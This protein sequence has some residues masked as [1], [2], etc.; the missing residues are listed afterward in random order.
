M[1]YVCDSRPATRRCWQA[2]THREAGPKNG[3]PDR[4]VI[5]VLVWLLGQSLS[6]V[7]CEEL[8]GSRVVVAGNSGPRLAFEG[9][10]NRPTA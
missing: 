3:G 6:G 4:I 5:G 7:S 9:A 2:R 10:A 1:A 8:A